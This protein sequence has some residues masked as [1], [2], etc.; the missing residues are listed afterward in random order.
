MRKLHTVIQ[1]NKLYKLKMQQDLI[2]ILC[3]NIYNQYKIV[4]LQIL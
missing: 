3:N 1:K 2:V 4:K